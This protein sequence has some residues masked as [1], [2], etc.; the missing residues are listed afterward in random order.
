[1]PDASEGVRWPCCAVDGI[2]RR[3]GCGTR[4]SPVCPDVIVAARYA[5]NLDPYIRCSTG[6]PQLGLIIQFRR[7]VRIGES[8]FKS[9][10]PNELAVCECACAH[11]IAEGDQCRKIRKSL[12][13]VVAGELNLHFAGKLARVEKRDKTGTGRGPCAACRVGG[14]ETVVVRSVRIQPSNVGREGSD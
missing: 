8:Q 12:P 14:E 1:M 5:W 11:S 9:V 13:P 2:R 10:C 3:R 4:I 6:I 7:L